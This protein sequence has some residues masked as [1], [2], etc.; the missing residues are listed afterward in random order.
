MNKIR[1]SKAT[2]QNRLRKILDGIDET[3]SSVTSITLGG[4][5]RT[6]A[7]LKKLIEADLDAMDASVKARAAARVAVQAERDAHAQIDPILRLFKAAIL[8]QFGDGVDASAVLATFGFTPRKTA[9]QDLAT[10]TQAQGKAEATRIAR[11]TRGPKQKA[12]I[13]G[14]APAVEPT[15]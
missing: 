6:M 2:R 3:L 7:D 15:A 4:V 1:I 9:K 11:G 5:T 8:A 13:K 10:K 14:T 12:K